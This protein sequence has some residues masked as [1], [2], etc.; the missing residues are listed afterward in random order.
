[1][2]AYLKVTARGSIMSAD[3]KLI[4]PGTKLTHDQCD[5]MFGG[6]KEIDRLVDQGYLVRLGEQLDPDEHPLPPQT[7]VV[8]QSHP[9]PHEVDLN[10]GDRGMS[11]AAKGDVVVTEQPQSTAE[12][13][14]S[15]VTSQWTVDPATL[16]G[17]DVAELNVMISERTVPPN[18][19]QTFETPEEAVAWLS[20][21]RVAD[22]GAAVA[23]A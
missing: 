20:Q 10:A 15:A 13:V 18:E 12:P 23:S 16:I 9:H 2:T 8:Q 19:V 17:K 14:V 21:D 4:V 1:M 3:R 11:T 6:G 7:N 5:K 22:D